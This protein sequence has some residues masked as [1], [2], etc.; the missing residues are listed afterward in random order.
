MLNMMKKNYKK[1]NQI[2]CLCLSMQSISKINN[3]NQC[4]KKNG[5]HNKY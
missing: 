4:T 3:Y 2:L 1:N 5:R